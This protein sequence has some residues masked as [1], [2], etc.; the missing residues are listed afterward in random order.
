MALRHGLRR[1]RRALV[2]ADGAAWIWNLVQ[3][4]FGREVELLDFYHA[5]QH[6]WAVAE[7]LF[8]DSPEQAR[9]WAE[10]LLHRLRHG[11]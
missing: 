3:N 6:L 1:A 10:P 9:S 4:R 11:G 7:A 5:S 2:I 8:P